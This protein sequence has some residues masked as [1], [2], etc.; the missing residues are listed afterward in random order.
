MGVAGSVRMWDRDPGSKMFSVVRVGVGTV[1]LAMTLE[2]PEIAPAADLEPATG[3]ALRK[4]LNAQEYID[5]VPKAIWLQRFPGI[6][7]VGDIEEGRSLAR[8]ILCQLAAFHSPRPM[9]RSLWSAELRS[10]G[11]GRSGC[12]IFSMRAS[13]TGAVSARLLFASPAELE[14][15]FDEDPDGEREQWSQP[16]SSLSGG[17]QGALPLRVIIDDSCATPEDWAG[18]TGCL[19]VSPVP[20]L[21]GWARR[22]RHRRCRRCRAA[23]AARLAGWG[24]HRRRPTASR[25]VRFASGC[26]WIGVSRRLR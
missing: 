7:I 12:H 15:F 25:A 10:S 11:N 18:L 23:G 1:K 9:Y 13:A 21:F 4:F 26:R 8:A 17:G 20:A 16:S 14:A 5:D 22:S 6:S 19:L 24:S 2:K 3:H